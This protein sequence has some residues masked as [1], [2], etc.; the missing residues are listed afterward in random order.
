MQFWAAMI[1]GQNIPMNKQAVKDLQSYVG[2]AIFCAMLAATL[3]VSQAEQNV[4]ALFG[5]VYG[6]LWV[7]H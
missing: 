1:G 2:A 5:F 4:I 7:N 3:G 6:A